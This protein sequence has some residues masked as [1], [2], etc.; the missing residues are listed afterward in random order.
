ME[1]YD[2]Y[3]TKPARI[4]S[5][6]ERMIP[7]FEE[8]DLSASGLDTCTE[9]LGVFKKLKRA[10]YQ[11]AQAALQCEREKSRKNLISTIPGLKEAMGKMLITSL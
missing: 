3:E 4:S 6:A 8:G 7:K 2:V 1:Y 5:A 9:F 11:A 10:R